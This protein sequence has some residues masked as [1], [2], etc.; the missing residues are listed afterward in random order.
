MDQVFETLVRKELKH[1][2]Q[3]VEQMKMDAQRIV[4]AANEAHANEL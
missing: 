1:K 4:E 2:K 3:D